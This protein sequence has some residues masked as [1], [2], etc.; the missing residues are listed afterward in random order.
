[1]S[2]RSPTTGLARA[3]RR[4][5]KLLARPAA[6]AR[7]PGGIVVRPYRGFG[8]A[9]EGFLIGRVYW[10]PTPHSDPH[11]GTLRRALQD[12]WRL[13]RRHG[14]ADAAV[15]ARFAGAEQRVATDRDGYFHLHLRPSR[16]PPVD[17]LWHP[18]GI[19]LVT[20]A[21]VRAEGELFIPPPTCRYVV[22]SDIDDTIMET[23]V[24][25]KL[26]MLRR[27][28]MQRAESRVA[29]P[30]V[31]AFLD[32]LHGGASGGDRNPMLYVSRAPWSIYEVLEEF[33]NLHRIPTG[34][35]LFLREWGLTLQRPLP[36]RGKSHKLD[37]IRRMLALYRDLPFVLL[38][39][40]G[41]RDPEI[42]TRV[43]R[44][45]PG[46]VLAIYIRNVSRDPE[47]Q[48]AIE[49]LAAEVAGAGSTLLLAADSRAMA[50]HAAAHGLI[51]R[52]A[53]AA[54]AREREREAAAEGEA[55]AQPVREV[56]RATPEETR[57]AVERGRL[58]E[59]LEPEAGE[60]TPPNVVIEPEEGDARR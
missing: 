58:R 50:E 29:F 51:R 5:L 46:R 27:L 12:L 21:T 31:A 19:E 57:A 20:P 33:F 35:V 7:G 59:A 28:F 32:A 45:N 9:E 56:V 3:L 55:E 47:R 42:Y 24:A 48:R 54:V 6:G 13:L 2:P 16:R 4:A 22:I 37:L 11:D 30:G 8:T 34:P 43:V 52:E 53:C 10:Q 38:G 26:T 18:V 14:I 40:S 41:Q 25:N 15:H 60:A 23:G 39:D 36:R 17:R 44:E 1:M 49:A